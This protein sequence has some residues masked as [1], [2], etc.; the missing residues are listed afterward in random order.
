MRN[1][2]RRCATAGS[3]KDDSFELVLGCS[4]LRRDRD[5][6]HSSEMTK[7]AKHTESVRPWVCLVV[8]HASRRSLSIS[9]NCFLQDIRIDAHD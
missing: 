3:G 1:R 6:Q 5:W 2:R 9:N 8:Q 4:K 7:H